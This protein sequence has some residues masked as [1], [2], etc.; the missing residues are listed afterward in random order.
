ML[1]QSVGPWALCAGVTLVL[2]ALAWAL[3]GY[4]GLSFAGGVA[5]TL[6]IAAPVAVGF[7]FMDI[8]VKGRRSRRDR[9]VD[10]TTR[11]DG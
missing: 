2:I 9:M 4:D 8:I 6:G 5:L 11:H 1:H 10:R 3:G 7:A